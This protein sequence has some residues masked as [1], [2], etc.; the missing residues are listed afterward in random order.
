MIAGY[1]KVFNIKTLIKIFK[2]AVNELLALISNLDFKNT[3]ILNKLLA[4]NG[5]G[6][7][8]FIV[9]KLNRLEVSTLSISV[10]YNQNSVVPVFSFR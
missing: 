2:E 5:G 1:R 10:D 9:F 8:S 3:V 6:F 7:F 4:D